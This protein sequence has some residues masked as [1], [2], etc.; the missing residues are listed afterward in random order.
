MGK[1]GD[2]T[3]RGRGHLVLPNANHENPDL[4]LGSRES[5]KE[6]HFPCAEIARTEKQVGGM[7]RSCPRVKMEKNK[8]LVGCI[9]GPQLGTLYSVVPPHSSL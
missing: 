9:P 6:E 3:W 1:V 4:A 7:V 5:S 2:V 8:K